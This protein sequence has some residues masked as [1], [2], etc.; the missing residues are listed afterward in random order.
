MIEPEGRGSRKSVWYALFGTFCLSVAL[1]GAAPF[2]LGGPK[3]SG[4]PSGSI[5][6]A[7]ALAALVLLASVAVAALNMRPRE[8][9]RARIT[10]PTPSEFQTTTL[11]A[12]ALSE[13]AAVIGFVMVGL[14]SPMDSW[15]FPAASLLVN[16]MVILPRAIQY[17]AESGYDK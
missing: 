11:I 10:W 3:A 4:D 14:K 12:L 8:G 5:T 1:I 2:L 16:L 17:W 9:T 13:V 7:Y 15:P 6:M